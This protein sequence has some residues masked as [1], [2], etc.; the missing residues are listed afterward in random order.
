[1]ARPERG[2]PWA[3]ERLA[4]ASGGFHLQGP[5]VS[6]FGRASGKG[7]PVNQTRL[8]ETGQLGPEG[9]QTLR[10][11][12][13]RPVAGSRPSKG[14]EQGPEGLGSQELLLTLTLTHRR[15]LPRCRGPPSF[16][17]AI[18][19]TLLFPRGVP[20]HPRG[21]PR[22]ES[23]TAHPRAEA[24]RLCPR[25]SGPPTPPSQ[26]RG[27]GQKH[28]RAHPQLG[29]APQSSREEL[30]PRS[31]PCRARATSPFKAASAFSAPAPLIPDCLEER[32]INQQPPPPP[33]PPPSPACFSLGSF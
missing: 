3:E 17:E 7:S 32:M 9:G 6:C 22:P 31:Q 33:P 20:N 21:F 19:S 24:C 2:Q 14:A 25:R 1:M 10:P 4:F 28:S 16:S 11:A 29:L 30:P 27:P 5:P 8:Q 12:C 15:T 26:C 23:I 13:R 18:L